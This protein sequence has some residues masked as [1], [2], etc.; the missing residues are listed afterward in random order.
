ME[1][2][3]INNSKTSD[4]LYDNLMNKSFNNEKDLDNFYSQFMNSYPYNQKN[5]FVNTSSDKLVDNNKFKLISK[6][7][8]PLSPPHTYPS[9][10]SSNTSTNSE[11]TPTMISN[12]SIKDLR[13]LSMT[14]ATTTNT[15]GYST[16][17]LNHDVL[18]VNE[19]SDAM[20]I[21]TSSITKNAMAVRNN[22]S[23]GI[24]DRNN[25]SILTTSLP[26]YTT[27]QTS[28]ATNAN[29][30]TV[31]KAN[32]MRIPAQDDN[33]QI[34]TDLYSF[35][36]QENL[37]NSN[38]SRKLNYNKFENQ[39]YNYLFDVN[40]DS[41]NHN[42]YR[43]NTVPSSHSNINDVLMDRTTGI[44]SNSMIS[45]SSS[46]FISIN[47]N[48]V[49][50]NSSPSLKSTENGQSSLFTPLSYTDRDYSLANFDYS[51]VTTT[52]SLLPG[53]MM[54]PSL[55]PNL[56]FT[57][58]PVSLTENISSSNSSLKSVE[59]MIES[60]QL[61]L[62][63]LRKLTNMIAKSN[64]ELFL[65]TQAKVRS[66]VAS[67]DPS[68]N[69]SE[70]L[71]PNS[72]TTGTNN[73][74]YP[75]VSPPLPM[76]KDN[77]TDVNINVTMN[78][79]P[80]STS[81]SSP[82]QKTS[83]TSVSTPSN[84]IKKSE[85][86]LY[87]SPSVIDYS[88]SYSM[89]EP[90]TLSNNIFTNEN[91]KMEFMKQ[92]DDKVE[93]PKK[94]DNEEQ[95]TKDKE[96]IEEEKDNKEKEK[97]SEDKKEVKKEEEDK[98][99]NATS[100]TTTTTT[101]TTT[102]TTATTTPPVKTKRRYKRKNKD[103]F[104]NPYS[105]FLSPYGPGFFGSNGLL[106]S[107]YHLIPQKTECANCK[108]TKTPLW[109]RSANDEIL[110]NAC[111]LYQKI[112]NAPR[113]KTNRINASRKDFDDSEKKKI[114]CSNCKTSVTPLWRRDKEGNPL[115][116]ACGL[117]KTLHNGASRPIT[118]KKSVPRKR[119]RNNNGEG[120]GKKE[121]NK[122]K[123]D[124]DSESKSKKVK[125]NVEEKSKDETDIAETTISEENTDK[126][127]KEKKNKK[128]KKKRKKKERKK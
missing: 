40:L 66:V 39:Y 71:M 80:S 24:E 50:H 113:P 37:A 8:L 22:I 47:P 32:Y 35:Y 92:Q 74:T 108:V 88:T 4:M 48:I 100:S 102:S 53:N 33:D 118:L 114:K 38:P 46:S 68:L 120:K 21:T 101:T 122:R 126:K 119:Q 110:C 78:N 98:E 62:N 75:M 18:Y 26:S 29:S 16:P 97:S 77:N 117:Y 30:S 96:I 93:I 19:L 41:P 95:T 125:L 36:R 10:K 59:A 63:Q 49:R 45:D 52:N 14:S 84:S 91:I 86:P 23:F 17:N 20:A 72:Y 55:S 90:E 34:V 27:S 2:I 104:Y 82:V 94:D 12:N 89:N 73:M 65:Q 99:K 43:R 60:N 7:D 76:D 42:L 5:N 85:I 31:V 6:C 109:R 9:P 103:L 25:A 116:N 69:N 67:Q 81:P 79:M 58:E 124:T 112:H 64:N 28:T 123:K 51:N 115:C 105:R 13:R 44:S 128:G 70:I 54:T 107:P 3:F 87:I 57:N 15:L 11:D 56:S 127:T 61:S 83:S 111:G 121:T 106:Y 1:S